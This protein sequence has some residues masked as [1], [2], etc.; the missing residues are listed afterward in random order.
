M[1]SHRL[2]VIDD[3]AWSRHP[4]RGIFHRMGWDVRVAGTLAE[5]LMAL[6]TEP[7][8]CCLVLDLGLPD[9]DGEAVLKRVRDKGY[10]TRV[11]VAT[12]VVD[13]ERL[14]SVSGLSPDALLSKPIDLADV[15]SG[16]VVCRVCGQNPGERTTAPAGDARVT[17]TAAQP[18]PC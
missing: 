14:R 1:A 6:E 12:G 10:Q 13:G 15:W 5:G 3:H 17:A 9:G 11:V 18:S 2:L 16:D 8:P 7:E 4:L